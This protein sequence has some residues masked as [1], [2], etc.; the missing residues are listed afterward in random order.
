MNKL[1]TITVIFFMIL[2]G[3]T[4]FP[5]NSLAQD[6]EN[7]VMAG[8]ILNPIGSI[9]MGEFER[10][11]NDK[12][13]IAARVGQIDYDVDY[14]EDGGTT[15]ETG[16]GPGIECVFRLYPG[17]ALKGFYFGGAVGFW[18]TDW[19]WKWKGSGSSTQT[20]SGSST[21]LDINFT[22][23]GKIY[24]APDKVFIDPSFTI[25]NFFADS[26]GKTGEVDE[27]GIYAGIGIAVGFAF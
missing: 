15:N 20:G 14:D 9:V 7:A 13:T 12:I 4:A 26:N 3:Y 1:I 6:P 18:N 25:G 5:T 2:V 23:G 10:R 8:I 19:E 22:L 17:Q 24:V 27:V 11:L 21:A 16:D